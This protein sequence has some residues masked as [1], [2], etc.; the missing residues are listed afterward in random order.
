MKW[1]IA[2]LI[3]WAWALFAYLQNHPEF[4]ISLRG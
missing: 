3:V 1:Q 2:A 4:F